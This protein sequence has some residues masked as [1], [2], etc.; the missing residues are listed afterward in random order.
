MGKRTEIREY[1]LEGKI[2]NIGKICHENRLREFNSKLLHRL[3]VTKKEL[4]I[5]G[6][7]DENNCPYCKEPD[8]ILHTFVECHYTQ[9]FYVKV[10]D[11]FNAKFNCAFSPT[12][13]EILFGTDLNTS[14]NNE[15]KLNC[16]LLFAK[17][18]LY[19]QKMYYKACNI[20]EFVLKLEQKLLIESRLKR[21]FL[22][23]KCFCPFTSHLSD[24]AFS[25]AYYILCFR[26]FVFDHCTHCFSSFFVLSLLYLYLILYLI[27]CN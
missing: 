8:S 4:C 25:N 16:C 11:W 26:V 5:Y 3:A 27:H 21:K 20:T 14:R 19:Y 24:L 13:H 7:N 1:W 6:L 15:L 22:V 17:Y 9:S 10:V 12:P 23:W 2:N 18:Y